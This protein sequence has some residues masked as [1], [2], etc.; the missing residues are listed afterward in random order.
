ML[1]KKENDIV[2]FI[3]ILILIITLFVTSSKMNDET[4]K[5]PSIKR[6]TLNRDVK[7]GFA[8]CTDN[9]M[10]ISLIPDKDDKTIQNL[11]VTI[12]KDC[13]TNPTILERS[14]IIKITGNNTHTYFQID[15]IIYVDN[16]NV[17]QLIQKQTYTNKGGLDNI[18]T[19][20][21]SIKIP[22]V[23][24]FKVELIGTIDN[25]IYTN[26]YN[27][28]KDSKIPNSHYK[29]SLNPQ[30]SDKNIK[31]K[32]KVSKL[33]NTEDLIEIYVDRLNGTGY[34]YLIESIDPV[35]NDINLNYYDNDVNDDLTTFLTNDQ[36]LNCN[37]LIIKKNINDLVKQKLLTNTSTYSDYLVNNFKINSLQNKLKS[38]KEK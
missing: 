28:I 22:D 6:Y 27:L 37:M 9:I 14:N 18:Q 32:N 38:I 29:L 1:S 23:T 7:E 17:V 21:N 8:E 16:P 25:C 19:K 11:L 30:N 20:L 2:I 4:K 3:L 10:N 36:C 15:D 5:T 26:Y 33:L 35:N 13:V 31:L 34:L 12:R 24:D